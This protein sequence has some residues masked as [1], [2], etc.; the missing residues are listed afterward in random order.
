MRDRALGRVNTPEIGET[1]SG[2]SAEKKKRRFAMDERDEEQQD[3]PSNHVKEKANMEQKR[4]KLDEERF[5]FDKWKRE[6]EVLRVKQAQ[7]HDMKV[8]A[9]SE[10]SIDLEVERA[11]LDRAER[12][13]ALDERRQIIR[14]LGALA[15]KL[16]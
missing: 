12:K 10:K 2:S 14:V 4:L 9:L 5:E 11:A 16:K 7:E 13:S 8:L 6:E 1:P 3:L 15:E